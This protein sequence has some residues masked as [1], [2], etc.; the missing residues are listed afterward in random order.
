VKLIFESWRR[1]GETSDN[2]K[3]DQWNKSVQKPRIKDPNL[4]PTSALPRHVGDQ[5]KSFYGPAIAQL[6]KEPSLSQNESWL[7]AHF[8]KM[9]KGIGR[10]A[11][12]IKEAPELLL[13]VSH[14]HNHD[15]GAFTNEKEKEYFNKYPEFFPKVYITSK[16]YEKYNLAKEKEKFA[17]WVVVEKVKIPNEDEY[18]AFILTAFPTVR[19][20]WETFKEVGIVNDFRGFKDGKWHN[21][22]SVDWDVFRPFLEGDKEPIEMLWEKSLRAKQLYIKE[23]FVDRIWKILGRD[24]KLTRLRSI[25]SELGI[26]A[27]DIRADNVGTRTGKEFLLIDIGIFHSSHWDKLKVSSFGSLI[28]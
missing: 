20:I 2:E 16:T 27:G 22:D 26:T 17:S 28:F 23:S 21:G 13:K 18:D 5:I 19:K 6:I 1:F 24:A 25:I 10:Q 4:K 7:D 11:Y 12:A 15:Y 3:W 9:G 14:A 8:V